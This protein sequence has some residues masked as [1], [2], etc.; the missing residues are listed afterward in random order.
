VVSVSGSVL[1]ALG[2][3]VSLEWWLVRS[4]ARPPTSPPR[5]GIITSA[6]NSQES[7]VTLLAGLSYAGL[8]SSNK[9]SSKAKRVTREVPLAARR[10][11]P[12]PGSCLVMSECRPAYAYSSSACLVHHKGKKEP[13]THERAPRAPPPRAAS[14]FQHGPGRRSD[15]LARPACRHACWSSGQ[16][17]VIA[18][19]WLVWW[20]GSFSFGSSGRIL[21][22]VPDL[23]T[24]SLSHPTPR[25][26][27]SPDVQL[28]PIW[29]FLPPN[30]IPPLRK[31]LAPS[32]AKEWIHYNYSTG[33]IKCTRT[34]NRTGETDRYVPR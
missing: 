15:W 14:H 32:R 31:N 30:S 8:H 22:S 23:P 10:G 17:V 3:L 25:S 9:Y 16:G 19:H 27:M 5:G 21:A 24:L 18:T 1:I 2:C 11:A 6:T 20:S 12:P 13:Y 7:I 28:S 34:R 26:P 29:L 4:S 33:Q